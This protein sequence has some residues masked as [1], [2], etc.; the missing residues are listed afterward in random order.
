MPLSIEAGLFSRLVANAHRGS[1]YRVS[2]AA[3]HSCIAHSSRHGQVSPGVIAA[4]TG[5]SLHDVEAILDDT[6]LAEELNW[7]NWPS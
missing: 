7:P 5:H 6:N 4:I 2:N 1:R 3:S